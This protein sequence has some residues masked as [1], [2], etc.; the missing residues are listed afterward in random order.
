MKDIRQLQTHLEEKRKESFFYSW[1]L[2]RKYSQDEL[3][4][5]EILHLIVTAVFEPAGEECGT[6]YDEEKGCTHIFRN[7]DGK[8]RISSR[9]V[10]SF[11]VKDSCGVGATQ[12]SEL[13]LDLKRI[14]T[15]KDVAETIGGQTVVAAGLGRSLADSGMTG[16]ALGRV[17]SATKG[18]RQSETSKSWSQLLINSAPIPVSAQTRSGVNYLDRDRQGVYRWTFGHV[19][20]L[21][22]L[23]ELFVDRVA[24]DGS[25]VFRTRE[26]FGVRR[27]VLRPFAPRLIT[28]RFYAALKRAS[29]RGFRVEVTL[30]R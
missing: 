17:G 15:R 22:L 9:Q 5:A 3:D 2:I 25:D 28:Q 26:H 19:L 29:A 7:A 4:S 12:T 30:F 16:F 18:P 8:V 10:L 27:G 21:N 13:F 20:G 11:N 14:P 6:T 24:W 1:E 23:S